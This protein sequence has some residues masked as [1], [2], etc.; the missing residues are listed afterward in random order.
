MRRAAI[1]ISATVLVWLS[2]A[3]PALAQPRRSGPPRGALQ[4][5][6]GWFM[7]SGSS[8]FWDATEDVFT[9]DT[10]D[11]DGFVLGF[12]Y[13][14]SINNELE[15]GLNVDFY[16]ERARSQYR[17]WVDENGFP[18]FH[19]TKLGLIPWT[20]DVR[21]IPGG[22]YRL[23]PGGRFIR[24]PLFYIGGGVGFVW[25]E[26]E[27]VGDFLDFDFDPPEIFGSRF[28]DDGVTFEAHALAGVEVPVGQSINLMFEGRY[29]VAEDDLRGDFAGLA[30]TDLDLGGLAIY[31]GF[32]FRF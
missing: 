9:L 12:S 22:R 27:E 7:P 28:S 29:S 13:V 31:A 25:W 32:N 21:F 18:I 30:E 17:D 3:A 8:D 2:V 15:V 16:D 26:Y 23:R 10:S 14:R 1:A 4:V 24:K 19:D 20:V 11:L 6:I 5:R